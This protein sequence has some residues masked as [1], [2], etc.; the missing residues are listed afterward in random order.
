MVGIALFSRYVPQKS[1]RPLSKEVAL[2][3]GIPH[4]RA[5]KV[6]SPPTRAL[7]RVKAAWC[8]RPPSLRTLSLL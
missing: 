8:E 5:R 3:A 6:V 2:L 4:A 7:K 1:S